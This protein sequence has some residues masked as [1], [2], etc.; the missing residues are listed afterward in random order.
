MFE[1]RLSAIANRTA[2]NLVIKQS[3]ER[4]KQSRERTKLARNRR[5]FM[6][7]DTG[8]SDMM[9][10]EAEVENL[11]NK[12]VDAMDVFLGITE[13]DHGVER[14]IFFVAKV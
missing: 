8:D 11:R 7:M 4:I 12:S 10:S 1:F 5:L 6:D 14:V 3:R 2:Q 9:E 13:M